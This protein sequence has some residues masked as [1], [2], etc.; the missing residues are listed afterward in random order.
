MCC[1]ARSCRPV[2]LAADLPASHRE[3]RTVDFGTTLPGAFAFVTRTASQRECRRWRNC[4]QP[5]TFQVW[6]SCP[7][8]CSGKER[9]DGHRVPGLAETHD[10]LGMDGTDACRHG[11]FEVSVSVPGGGTFAR[12]GETTATSVRARLSSAARP[13]LWLAM[14][15]RPTSVARLSRLEGEPSRCRFSNQSGLRPASVVT[16]DFSEC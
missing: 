16:R 15:L 3:N 14:P 5:R 7:E 1:P 2:G 9:H 13:S 6:L 4:T 10:G 11:E 12:S 8:A